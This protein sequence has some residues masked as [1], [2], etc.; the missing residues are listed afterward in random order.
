M[1]KSIS[2]NSTDKYR[3]CKAGHRDPCSNSESTIVCVSLISMEYQF[4]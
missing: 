3:N 1:N 2:L 4:I